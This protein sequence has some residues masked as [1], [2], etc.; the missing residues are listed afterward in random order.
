VEWLAAIGGI[1]SA[2]LG[3]TVALMGIR[4]GRLKT[5]AAEADSM[6]KAA[7]TNLKTSTAKFEDYRKRAESIRAELIAE[8]ERFQ[9]ERLDGIE[10][11]PDRKIRV[12][13]R[14]AWVSG[15]LSKAS[16]ITSDNSGDRLH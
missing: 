11:E 5:D 9:E 4:V 10:K 13:L 1:T 6:R 14:R 12:R 15:L 16:S 7:E 8:L 2:A 3:L